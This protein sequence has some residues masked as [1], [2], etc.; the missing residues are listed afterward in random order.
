MS[1]SASS[2]GPALLMAVAR[3]HA[4]M[5]FASSESVTHCA[6]T[7]GARLFNTRLGYVRSIGARR[8][9][10]IRERLSALSAA[11]ITDTSQASES[12]MAVRGQLDRVPA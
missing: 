6:S 7:T 8:Q 12:A 5:S 3:R 10:V 2:S 4:R 1:G 11:W 9:R